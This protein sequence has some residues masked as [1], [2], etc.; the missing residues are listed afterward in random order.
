MKIAASLS[1]IFEIAS[2]VVT[3]A[4]PWEIS[5]AMICLEG[6]C[7]Y[8]C[9]IVCFLATV[10]Q[11]QETVERIH[12]NAIQSHETIVSL[13]VIVVTLVCYLYGTVTQLHKHS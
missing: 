11:M 1:V 13:P 2:A 7:D 8:V 6:S 4:S 5:H 3:F 9:S 12:E 10:V